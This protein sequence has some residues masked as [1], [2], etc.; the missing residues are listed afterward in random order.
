MNISIIPKPQRLTILSDNTFDHRVSDIM[1]CQDGTIPAEGYRLEIDQNGIRIFCS[2]EA[3]AFYGRMTVRQL[4]A[5]GKL[6]ELIIED[7]PQ[8]V[9]RGLMLDCCRHF[10]PVAV[11]KG[12]LDQMAALKLNVLHWHLSD[13]QGIRIESKAYPQ[14]QKVGSKR[15]GTCGDQ[16]PVSGYYTQEEMREVVAYARQRHIHVMPEL[17]MPGHAAAA[18]AAYKGISCQQKEILVKET[19]GI[20]TDVLCPG[21]E[22]TYRFVFA[23]L[24][25]L[26]EIFPFPYIHLGGDEAPRT[27]WRTCPDCR[28]VIRENRLKNYD[29]LQALY[30]NRVAAYCKAHG[31]TVVNWNDGMK[32]RNISSEIVMQYWSEGP[33]QAALL[34]TALK[35][36]GKVI[37]SP[38]RNYYLDYSY[39]KTPLKK[40]FSYNPAQFGEGVLGVEATLWTEYVEDESQI[41]HQLFPRLLAV[42][43]RAW[44][45]WHRDFDGFLS[46]TEHLQPHF[47]KISI[48]NR[49]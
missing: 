3:G 41:Q 33:K 38:C 29:E 32:G 37:L 18:I 4:L 39:R 24:D 34:R 43:E 11:I 46:R 47:G 40:T 14:L 28:R 8:Y 10:F 12:L 26:F 17:E 5:Q 19:F 25:E 27:R 15:A 6:P 31:K 44:S 42:A 9:Y 20:H 45:E 2:D 21:K 23:V 36:G 13:D 48:D 35:R 7:Y 49:S 30:M 22:D 16:K 1:E